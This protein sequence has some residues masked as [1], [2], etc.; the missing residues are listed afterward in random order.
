VSPHPHRGTGR[1]RRRRDGDVG[2]AVPHQHRIEVVPVGGG[3][4]TGDVHPFHHH[5]AV[6]VGWVGWS[7]HQ[8][9]G[10]VG[11]QRGRGDRPLAVAGRG[12]GV[13]G[14]SGSRDEELLLRVAIGCKVEGVGGERLDDMAGRYRTG[15]G[16][17]GLIELRRSGRPPGLGHPI[18]SLLV[19]AG[20]PHE[21][22]RQQHPDCRHACSLGR[23]HH[24]RLSWSHLLRFLHASRHPSRLDAPAVGW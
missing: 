13:E 16:G 10:L 3:L 21:S 18:G 17:F 4:T 15:D 23:R 11:R 1:R 5:R 24:A 6:E 19:T 12:G 9:P 20:A 8:D 22:H 2:I 7:S 14:V